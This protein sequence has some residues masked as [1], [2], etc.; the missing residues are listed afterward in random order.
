MA[1]CPVSAWS[2]GA[3]QG[4]APAVTSAWHTLPADMALGGPRADCVRP[5]TSQTG[6][7]VQTGAVD[8]AGAS[9]TDAAGGSAFV[10]DTL[11]RSD[12]LGVGGRRTPFPP[13]LSKAYLCSAG[14]VG[15]TTLLPMFQAVRRTRWWLPDASRLVACVECQFSGGRNRPVV[16]GGSTAFTTRVLS[17]SDQET[18][19]VP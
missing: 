6:E 5:R 13:V 1:D 18:D 7:A 2:G 15:V 11:C 16:P 12:R 14:G 8:R 17:L 9:R 4:S 19:A 3:A 10:H